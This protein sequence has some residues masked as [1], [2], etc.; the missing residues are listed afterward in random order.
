MYRY[1]I[2]ILFRRDVVIAFHQGVDLIDF[3]EAYFIQYTNGMYVHSCVVTFMH[4]STVLLLIN[5]IVSQRCM[6]RSFLCDHLSKNDD[7]E[8]P[9]QMKNPA[10]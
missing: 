10:E 5:A 1:Q 9:L 7:V 3:A 8:L 2:D 4:C 6:H